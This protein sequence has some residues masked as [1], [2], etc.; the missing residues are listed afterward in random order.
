[1]DLTVRRSLHVA[2]MQ[3]TISAARFGHITPRQDATY[4]DTILWMPLGCTYAAQVDV[5]A[6]LCGRWSALTAPGLER[7]YVS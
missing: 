7:S 3:D 1:M 4:V 6:R 2:E 5:Q